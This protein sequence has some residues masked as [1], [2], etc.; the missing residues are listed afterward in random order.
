M[1]GGG[2]QTLTLR[3]TKKG[4]RMLAHAHN[5]KLTV[6]TS[7]LPKGKKKAIRTTSVVTLG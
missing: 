2:A 1:C 3:F 6:K 5:V 7:F 4:R